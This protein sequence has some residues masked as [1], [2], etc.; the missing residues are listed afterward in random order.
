MTDDWQDHL[1]SDVQFRFWNKVATGS[2]DECW[3]WIGSRTGIKN[4]RGQLYINGKMVKSSRIAWVIANGKIPEGM[5]VLHYCDNGLCCNSKHL[6]LGTHQDNMADA[7]AKGLLRRY[8]KFT[9]EQIIEIRNLY[10][11]MRLRS[12]AARYNTTN[13]T[14]LQIVNRV[15]Y[16]E[17]P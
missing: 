7:G 9:P 5:Y 3:D 8:R 10:G 13:P 14:I 17:V 6:F 16:K 12:L 4:D 1:T 15:T 11:K 2:K